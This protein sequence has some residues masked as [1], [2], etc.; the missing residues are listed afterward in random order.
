MLLPYRQHRC[1]ANR[2]ALTAVSVLLFPRHQRLFS[3]EKRKSVGR[4]TCLM[5]CPWAGKYIPAPARVKY[6]FLTT[7][8]KR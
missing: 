6:A 5:T 3:F 2:Q 8:C 4:L 1:R 7:K